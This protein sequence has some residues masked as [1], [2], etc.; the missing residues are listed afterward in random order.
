MGAPLVSVLIPCYNAAPWL[1]E[2]LQSVLDQTWPHIEIILV[3]DGSTDA[4]LAEV[5]RL[6]RREIKVFTQEN[7]GAASAR[8]R[9]LEE[10]TGDFIQYLD[11]DDVLAPDKIARQVARLSSSS[12]HKVASSEWARFTDAV[13]VGALATQS[14]WRDLSP[15]E[16]L[17]TCALEEL[18][19]PPISWLIP[20]PV[21]EA[22]GRWD[23][24]LSLNDDGEYMSRVL[25]CSDGI[26]FVPGA[27]AYY[28]SGNP[29]S[30]ASQKTERAARSELLAWDL[31]ASTML[32]LEDSARTRRAIATGYQRVQSAWFLRNQSVVE[33]AQRKERAFGGGAYQFQGGPA[34]CLVRHLLGW[35]TA[36]RLRHAAQ[37]LRATGGL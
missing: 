21:A 2:T 32:E 35:R 36:L 4:T 20:R 31:T 17:V 33:E 19:F 7:G 22:A 30:Y 24:R 23:E 26:A 34:F 25:A 6:Q 9:G 3:D 8:N 18:M 27:R 10:A 1:R 11:A 29:S 14:I 37:R 12:P 28:R 5:E 13:P 15:I 16:F